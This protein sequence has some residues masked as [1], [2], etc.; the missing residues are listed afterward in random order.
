MVFVNLNISLNSIGSIYYVTS[1]HRGN[2]TC[3][4]DF[5]DGM[6]YILYSNQYKLIYHESFVKPKFDKWFTNVLKQYIIMEE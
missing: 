1:E 6:V 5:P 2:I 3:R 4:L